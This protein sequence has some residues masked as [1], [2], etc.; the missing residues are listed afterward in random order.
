MKYLTR[1][2][3]RALTNEDLLLYIN[4]YLADGKSMNS[5][6]KYH[7]TT[8]KYIKTRLNELN[9]VYNQTTKQYEPITVEETNSSEVSSMEQTEL[10]L[11][12]EVL[13]QIR[14]ILKSMDSNVHEIRKNMEQ[15]DL[16]PKQTTTIVDSKSK[17]VDDIKPLKSD[18][19]LIIRNFKV[20]PS[21]ANRL[22]KLTVDTDYQVQQVFNALLDEVL[23]KYGY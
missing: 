14:D 10:H 13:L 20:Y 9:V 18:E 15:V 17:S 2:E 19:T 21:V 7:H 5:F 3:L 4:N 12:E 23:T 1:D 22:K 16:Q 6:E 11:Q 8:K